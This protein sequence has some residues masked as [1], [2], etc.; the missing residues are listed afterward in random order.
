RDRARSPGVPRVRAV[1]QTTCRDARRT[2]W[3][4]L[5]EERREDEGDRREELDEDVEARPGGV[6]ER[7]SD[8]VADDGSCVRRGALAEHSA[9]VVLQHPGLDVFL[10]VVPRAAAVVEDGG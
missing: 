1:V 4:P 3:A 7:I 9:L 10:R 2:R 6:L 5:D 8:G